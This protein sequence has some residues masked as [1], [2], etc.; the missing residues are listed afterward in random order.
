MPWCIHISWC[1]PCSPREPGLLQGPGSW[2]GLGHSPAS[3]AG[4]AAACSAACTPC[5]RCCYLQ[6]GDCLDQAVPAV[7]PCS[8]WAPSCV[9]S[10]AS[11]GIGITGKRWAAALQGKHHRWSLLPATAS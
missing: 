4:Q 8:A 1:S 6:L 2:H 3:C 5:L 7:Y 9:C 11:T 10:C